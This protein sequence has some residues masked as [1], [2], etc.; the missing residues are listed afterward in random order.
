[1]KL[2]TSP[3]RKERLGGRAG[4]IAFGT[5]AIPSRL[6]AQVGWNIGGRNTMGSLPFKRRPRTPNGGYRLGRHPI[7]LNFELASGVNPPHSA[8]KVVVGSQDDILKSFAAFHVCCRIFSGPTMDSLRL[9]CHIRPNELGGLSYPN[10]LPRRETIRRVQRMA[11][12]LPTPT[13]SLEIARF[14][15]VRSLF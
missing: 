2:Q 12:Q 14:S 6:A 1:M 13:E 9:R 8:I 3:A 4:T 15:F 10:T 7:R 11:R 5:P